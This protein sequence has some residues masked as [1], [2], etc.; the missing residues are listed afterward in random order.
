MTIN[1]EKLKYKTIQNI[2]TTIIV[3]A[4]LFLMTDYYK[5]C[6]EFGSATYLDKSVRQYYQYVM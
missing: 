4:Y 2:S 5:L 1:H 3:N 6:N